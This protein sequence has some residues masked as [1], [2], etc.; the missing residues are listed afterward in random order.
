[1]GKLFGMSNPKVQEAAPAVQ[2]VNTEDVSADTNN[3]NTKKKKP[4]GF[5]STQAGTA[6]TPAGSEQRQTLG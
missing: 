2:S 4:T 1:M 5:A 6:L 3:S